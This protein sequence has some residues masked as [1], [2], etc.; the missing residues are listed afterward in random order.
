VVHVVTSTVLATTYLVVNVA[1]TPLQLNLTATVA[2]GLTAGQTCV[3][4]G[5]QG[6]AAVGVIQASADF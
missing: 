6:S 5:Q 1:N 3:L 4:A 2:S